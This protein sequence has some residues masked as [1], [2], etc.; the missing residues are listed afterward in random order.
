MGVGAIEIRPLESADHAAW[1]TLWRGYQA[2]YKV[3]IPDAVSEVTWQRL[4]DPAEPMGGALAWQGARPVG[5]VHHIRHRS[6][7]TV[8]DYC[9]L[10]DLYV[11]GAIRGAGIGR[12]LI[13]HVYDVAA[14]QGCSRV[15][16]LTHETNTDAMM[17]YDRIADRSGFLQY[18][19][20]L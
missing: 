18:R 1:L 15:H 2:F 5:L 19:H 14:D 17:L 7:W 6:C 16:W 4:L 8:G 10:Q 9:Y 12:R 20:M 11:D 13:E 3:D